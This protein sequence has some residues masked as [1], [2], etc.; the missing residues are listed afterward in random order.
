MDLYP[1]AGV[2][3]QVLVPIDFFVLE[4]AI[5]TLQA[6]LAGGAVSL[7]FNSPL[8]GKVVK[9]GPWGWGLN[10]FPK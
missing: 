3:G 6:P 9:R 5:A 7:R 1:L 2:L 10:R 8:W 4:V